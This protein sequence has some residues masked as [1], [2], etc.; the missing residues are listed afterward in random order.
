MASPSQVHLTVNDTGVVK[1]KSQT[2][3]AAAKVSEL[4][5]ENHDKH[6]I[7]FN[8]SGFH[9]HIAHQL[10]SLYGVGAPASIIEQR[11]AENVSYQ[12]PAKS[13]DEV[14][15]EDLRSPET[16]TKCL[17]KEEY[18]HSF[19][20][21]FQ[22]E[23]EA[24]GW[25]NVLNEYLFSGNQKSEDLLG[26]LYGGF[27]HPIIHLGFGIEFHQ[28]AIIG[29]ALAQTACHDIWTG[30]YLLAAEKAA[31]ANPPNSPKTYVQL[32]DEI[33]QDKKL[34]TAAEWDDGN[35]IRDGIL[36]RAPE[37][38]MNYATQWVVTP[39]NLEQKTAEMINSTI[40][41]TAA[42]QHPP[43]QVKFDF[44]FMHCL[45]SSIFFPTFNEQ[46]WLS[47][48]NKVR[49]LQ[50]K[51]YL[52]LAMYASRRSPPLL[53][54]EISTYVPAKL[55]KGEGEWP[56]IFQRLWELE[57]DGHAIKL[58]RAV[59]NGELTAEKYGDV[60]SAKIRG[61]CGRRLEIWSL[62]AWRMMGI[63]GLEVLDLTRPGSNMRIVRDE[64]KFD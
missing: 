47:T 11:Y 37:E 51:G 34:S 15:V 60:E 7:F 31:K 6:H 20:V 12:R 30:K 27:L 56:G 53:L 59:R 42:A 22:A 18:Y 54:E 50:W 26:R 23:L 35:K 3:E 58:G 1:N 40:Y 17:G 55:E 19:L 38:M 5:Q 36:V 16:F 39:E 13:N 44:Y 62:T 25:E 43:K 52:D 14:A 33:K 61:L 2:N 63:I 32:L 24:K 10:L 28:P 57:D 21:F 64:H 9:N 48:A 4:L 49:L 29:E 46:S 45:N 8:E 41:F